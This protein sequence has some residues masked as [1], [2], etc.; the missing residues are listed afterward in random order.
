[1]SKDANK[2]NSR[3]LIHAVIVVMGALSALL[4]LMYFNGYRDV[5][6]KILYCCLAFILFGPII[7][8][9][10]IYRLVVG[11][12]LHRHDKRQEKV[13]QEIDARIR[14]EE[15]AKKQKRQRR[16]DSNLPKNW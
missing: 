6:I 4:V 3:A 15:H 7:N 14:R 9:T 11:Y 10:G 16:K 5:V 2:F 13:Y 12:I 8:R 1:M